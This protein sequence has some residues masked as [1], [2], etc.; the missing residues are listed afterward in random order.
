MICKLTCLVILYLEHYSNK[1]PAYHIQKNQLYLKNPEQRF[2]SRGTE[3]CKK[4]RVV[5]VFF[6]KWPTAAT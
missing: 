5:I 2:C 4:K 1:L 3:T 6:A